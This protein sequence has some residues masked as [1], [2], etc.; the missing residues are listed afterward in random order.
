MLNIP[1]V[2]PLQHMDFLCSFF[3]SAWVG[4]SVLFPC[5]LEPIARTQQAPMVI[6]LVRPRRGMYVGSTR[7]S[8]RLSSTRLLW[9]LSIA[10]WVILL[11]LLYSGTCLGCVGDSTALHRHNHL[12]FAGVTR[13]LAGINITCDS[14]SVMLPRDPCCCNV[15]I[16]RN[17]VESERKKNVWSH[18]KW[19]SSLFKLDLWQKHND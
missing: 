16:R 17:W 19:S 1:L 11:Y 18:D 2:D 15:Q 7:P 8:E 4:I 6:G 3:L 5:R 13:C 9:F 14:R 10:K 12:M